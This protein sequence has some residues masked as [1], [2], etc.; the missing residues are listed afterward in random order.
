VSPEQNHVD[1]D[2]ETG[3]RETSHPRTRDDP[4][5]E[6]VAECEANADS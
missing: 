1:D 5:V 2:C 6:N 4:S 3:N